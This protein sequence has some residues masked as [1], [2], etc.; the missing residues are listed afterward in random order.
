MTFESLI[1]SDQR[2]FRISRHVIFWIAWFLFLFATW[3]GLILHKII[4]KAIQ[5]D[6]LSALLRMLPQMPFCYFIIYFLFPRFFLRRR[7]LSGGILLI[8]SFVLFYYLQI[9]LQTVFDWEPAFSHPNISFGWLML[10]HNSGPITCCAVIASIKFLKIWYLK[11]EENVSLK[12]ENTLAELQLLKAQVHPHFLF[13]TLNNIYSFTLTKSPIAG[14]LLEKLSGILRYMIDEGYKP[15]VLLKKEIQLIHDYISL[16]RIRYG[17]RLDISVSIDENHD[18]KF[19]APLL[20]IPFVENSFKH[21]SSKMLK[22]P[23]VKL[24]ITVKDD[25]LIFFLCNNKPAQGVSSNGKGGVGLINV[26]KRLELLY[27]DRHELKI[28][29]TED[30]FSVSMT[31]DLADHTIPEASAR[32]FEDEDH[33]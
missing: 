10:T 9:L 11:Q 12:R 32:A 25:K 5:H 14:D 21:G 22:D 31:I 30:T 28:H 23:K 16:E 33:S 6:L 27:P 4:I 8:T 26:K 2:K 1:Y 17:D 19:V 29:S 18:N 13:N 3:G 20:M 7:F 15:A 24:K